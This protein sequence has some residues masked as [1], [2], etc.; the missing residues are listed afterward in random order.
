[1]FVSECYFFYFYILVSS[2]CGHQSLRAV[3]QGVELTEKQY[4]E[5]IAAASAVGISLND[6]TA[7][8]DLLT[9]RYGAVECTEMVDI[10]C[11]SNVHVNYWL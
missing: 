11:K 2:V 4:D 6:A 5:T 8:R 7:S 10:I 1:M 9:K 3:S